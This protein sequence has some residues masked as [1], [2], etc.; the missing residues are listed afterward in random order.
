MP[1]TIISTANAEHYKWGGPKGNDCD[2]WYLVKTAELNII[3]ELMPPGTA[4]TPHHHA[5]ARQFFFVL[6]GE[7]TLMVEYHDFGVKAGEGVEVAPGQMHQAINRSAAALRIVVTSQ[8][9]SHDDRIEDVAAA[10]AAN[11]DDG[12]V[13]ALVLRI[14]R[15]MMAGKVDV[16][17]LTPEMNAQLTPD[18]LGQAQM[19]FT[20]FGEPAK[21]TLKSK[22]PTANG[23]GYIFTGTLPTGDFQ[24]MIEVNAGGQV[25]GYRLTP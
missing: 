24:V 3:E 7:L 16:A 9:P 1:A 17:L 12:G 19:L 2:A 11:V 22:Q 25:A 13:T 20:A 4:E 18:V 14:Y 10:P 23:T 5:K 8:P 15:Q 21:L 6:E